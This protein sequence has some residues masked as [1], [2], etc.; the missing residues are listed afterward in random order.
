MKLKLISR[1]KY[2]FRF[3]FIKENGKPRFSFLFPI[4]STI[5]G[6]YIIFMIFSIMNGVNY[7]IEDR[8]NS[9]H[10]KYYYTSDQLNG[11]APKMKYIK[12]NNEIVYFE[13]NE[14]KKILNYFQVE[15]L[16]NYIDAKLGKYLAL[17][18]NELNNNDILIGDDF[19]NEHNFTIGDSIEIYFPSYLNISTKFIPSNLKQISGIYSIDLMD[20][21]KSTIIAS[22]D[23]SDY[24]TDYNY[25]FDI[26]DSDDVKYKENIILS[27]MIIKG[28]KLE[29]KIYYFFG[30]ISIIIS[31]FML[32]QINM[33]FIK[34]KSRQ[35]SL[36]SSLGMNNNKILLVIL[37]NNLLITLGS[38][39]IGY[40]LSNLTIYC[41]LNYD[42]FN[43]LY[44]AL[45]F[46][47]IYIN[48]LD[49]EVIIILLV[50]NLL[51]IISSFIPINII[52]DNNN[53]KF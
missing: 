18:E 24:L 28:M 15:D 1:Y 16:N 43:F 36:I 6:G 25:Y 22:Y 35:L 41:Y 48:L 19:A 20:Y 27:N 10:Y 34:E 13:E 5:I 33:Q 38:I 50:V 52:K 44:D 40:G 8:I 46:E 37:F 51:A 31:F 53:V 29:K 4:I 3:I 49:I 2:I 26:I 30:F 11:N 12:G 47:I 9:F 39:F 14:N 23:S 42:L 21:D 17:R 45:P 7:Q 32:F